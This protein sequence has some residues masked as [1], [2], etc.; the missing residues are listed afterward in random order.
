[1]KDING[2]IVERGT[3]LQST[4]SSSDNGIVECIDMGSRGALLKTEH[5]G[6]EPFWIS[7]ASLL[8]SMWRVKQI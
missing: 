8:S 1:M 4:Q 3:K 6:D 2:N 7:Q 5:F